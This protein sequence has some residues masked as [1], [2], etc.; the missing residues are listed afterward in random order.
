MLAFA[1]VASCGIG[2]CAEH[3]IASLCAEHVAVA[4]MVPRGVLL[5][6]DNV[7]TLRQLLPDHTIWAISV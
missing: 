5:P 4:S 2:F 3:A 7:K 1:F 6:S